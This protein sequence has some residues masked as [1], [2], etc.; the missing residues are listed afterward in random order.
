MKAG[1][2]DRRITILQPVEVE[3]PVYGPQ[4]ASWEPFISRI[5]AQVRD[6]LPSKAE[7]VEGGLRIAGRPSRVRTRYLRGLTSAMRVVVHGE[8]DEVYEI[9]GGPAEIGRREWTEFTIKAFT[10]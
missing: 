7:S 6:D 8:T 1:D 9:T 4:D 2:L 5:P 10:S 3:D